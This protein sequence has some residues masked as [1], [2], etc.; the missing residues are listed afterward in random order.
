[1]LRIK[2]EIS[3]FDIFS[4]WIVDILT[5]DLK[6]I[7]LV[8]NFH[9]K[10]KIR[11]NCD[12]HDLLFFFKSV[13][14]YWKFLYHSIRNALLITNLLISNQNSSEISKFKVF[15]TF[16]LSTVYISFPPARLLFYSF[17]SE[18][19]ILIWSSKLVKLH[20]IKF[21]APSAHKTNNFDHKLL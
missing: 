2:L 5:E 6:T 20:K 1:M 11:K 18:K 16:R 14:Y 19:L 10:A 15:V 3:Y 8:P 21:C 17:T 7:I 13:T 4:F 9:I 12:L